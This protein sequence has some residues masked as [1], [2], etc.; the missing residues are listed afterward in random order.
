ML[1]LV[2]AVVAVTITGYAV[3]SLIHTVRAVSIREI[4][5]NPRS[6]DGVYVRLCGYIVHTNYMF[7][8]TY[9]LRN[10]DD[11]AEIALGGKG[12]FK[13]ID[14][15]PY[16]SF[17]FDGRNYTQVR[18]LKVCVV[19]YVRFVGLVIDAPP[20]YLDVIEVEPN[21]TDLQ[22]IIVDFLKTTDIGHSG[23]NE[24]IKILEVYDHE[25]GGM[26]VVVSYITMNAV[27]PHFMCEA[28]EGHTA[29][30]TLNQNREVTSAF[31][32]WGS[33]H[34]SDRIWDIINQ[35]WIQK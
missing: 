34:G 10:V 22:T 26:V 5:S 27:H 6:F 21:I 30:I 2:C 24:T 3:D 4:T 1:V 32:M 35:R 17:V 33:F 7:G 9:V 25:L 11:N 13:N 8:P 14:F 28:I 29:V 19:G 23:W 15:E 12:G 18:N 16:V 20:F 31:C